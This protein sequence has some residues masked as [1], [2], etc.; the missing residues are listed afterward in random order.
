MNTDNDSDESQTASP[1]CVWKHLAWVRRHF[2]PTQMPTVCIE[3]HRWPIQISMLACRL[4]GNQA[5]GEDILINNLSTCIITH[6]RTD[7]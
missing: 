6:S 3:H 2:R 1:T 7:I 4:Y 5:L